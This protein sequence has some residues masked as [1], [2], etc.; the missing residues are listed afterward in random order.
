MKFNLFKVRKWAGIFVNGFFPV[1]FFF[2]GLLYYD[3]IVAIVLMFIGII[4]G[5]L[6][7][8]KITKHAFT[9]MLEGAG[10]L[11]LCIDSP[12][13]IVPFITTFN[14]PPYIKGLLGKKEVAGVYN[15]D[16]VHYLH[17]AKEAKLIELEDET[18][19]KITRYLKLPDEKEKHD[20]IFSFGPYPTFIFNKNLDS[21]LSKD[22]LSQFE[23]DIFTKQHALYILKKTENLSQAVR[24]FARYIVEHSKP[25]GGSILSSPW[26]K[27]ILIAVGIVVFLVLFLPLILDAIS[28]FDAGG[29]LPSDSGGSGPIT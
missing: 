20:S 9:D 27:W 8:N 19:G 12:G 14:E 28:G 3:F 1:F 6:I 11:T 15:R 25:R 24:D 16:L 22:A 23:K 17:K 4:L 2:V 13:V 29:I 10:L 21:F 7:F 26:L 18:T 5:A